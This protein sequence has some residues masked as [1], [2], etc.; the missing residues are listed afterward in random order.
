MKLFKKIANDHGYSVMDFKTNTNK[1]N[2]GRGTIVVRNNIINPDSID[3]IQKFLQSQ[4]III[5]KQS[6]QGVF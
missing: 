3:E 5:V 2:S 6:V 1:S 4:G